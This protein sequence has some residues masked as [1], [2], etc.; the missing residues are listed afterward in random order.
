[1][2]PLGCGGCNSCHRYSSLIAPLSLLLISHEKTITCYLPVTVSMLRHVETRALPGEGS[3]TA[4][5]APLFRHLSWLSICYVSLSRASMGVNQLAKHALSLTQGCFRYHPIVSNPKPPR[6]NGSGPAKRRERVHRAMVRISRGNKRCQTTQP[7]GRDGS[8]ARLCILSGSRRG[9]GSCGPQLSP[10][11][12]AF[13]PLANGASWTLNAPEVAQAAP[14]V[15]QCATGEPACGFRP[16]PPS[17]TAHASTGPIAGAL[18]WVDRCRA[19]HIVHNQSA[20]DCGSSLGGRR[21]RAS[22]R[23]QA[24]AQVFD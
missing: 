19:P 1:V 24:A 4:H 3:S 21:K 23:R 16:C 12:L 22:A 17:A 6:G 10:C 20:G 7:A 2:D 8:S 5:E 13:V 15:Q 18:P 11:T 14:W 9:P